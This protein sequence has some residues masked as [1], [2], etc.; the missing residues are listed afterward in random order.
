MG[1]SGLYVIGDATSAGQTEVANADQIESLDFQNGSDAI[2]LIRVPSSGGATYLDSIGYGTL[3]ANLVD[4]SRM[5]PVYEG[6]TV[7][8]PSTVTRPFSWARDE[9]QSDRNDNALDF[10]F[11]PE[12]TPGKVNQASLLEI[13]QISPPSALAT[14]SATVTISGLD[15]TDFMT[16]EIG[17]Q[18]IPNSQCQDVG[19]NEIEC[20]ISFTSTLA[21]APIDQSVSLTTRT[22]HGQ[23]VNFGPGFKWSLSV[24]ETDDPLEVDYCNIQFPASFTVSSSVSSDPILDAS[25]KAESPIQPAENHH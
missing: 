5:L 8:D 17:G 25:T 2:Q 12:P 20:L 18:V 19:R 21:F 23:T 3:T 22:E 1:G 6:N 11:E 24:N 16:L 4:Q 15:F 9:F 7:S 14:D 13:T 10:H